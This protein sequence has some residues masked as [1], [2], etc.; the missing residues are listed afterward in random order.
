MYKI[1]VLPEEKIRVVEA[2]LG[3]KGSQKVVKG[4]GSTL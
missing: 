2:Y 4:V 3:G 1:K